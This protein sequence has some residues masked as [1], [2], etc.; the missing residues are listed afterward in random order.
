MNARLLRDLGSLLGATAL[1]GL[2]STAACTPVVRDFGTGGG[3]GGGAS[4]GTTSTS[5]STGGGGGS[6]A[7]TPGTKIACYGGPAGTKGVG[8]CLGGEKT[9]NAEGDGYG[10]CKGEVTPQP[11][12]CMTSADEDCDGKTDPCPLT[13]LWANAPATVGNDNV[14]HGVA[15]DDQGFVYVTGTLDGTIVFDA[16]AAGQVTSAG[17]DD[18]YVAKYGP[19][20]AFLWVKT[21]GDASSQTATAIAV[22]KNGHVYVGGYFDGKV[23]FGASYNFATK[24]GRDAFVLELDKNGSTL[25]AVAGGDMSDQEITSLV[26]GPGGEVIVGGTFGGSF[27][28]TG[29]PLLVAE[30]FQNLFLARFDASLTPLFAIAATGP[31]PHSLGGLAVAPD[32]SLAF[33]GSFEG[34]FGLYGPPTLNT[35]DKEDIVVGKINPA[36]KALVWAHGYN[37]AGQD[38]GAGVAVDSLGNVLFGGYFG[39]SLDLGSSIVLQS[40]TEAS[41]FVAK[42]SPTGDPLW[43]QRYGETFPGLSLPLVLATTTNDRVI[44]GGCYFN[45]A[46]FGGGPLSSAGAANDLGAVDAFLAEFESSGQYVVARSFGNLSVQAGLGLAIAPQGNL[47][48]C[49]ATGGQLDFGTGPVGPMD[50]NVISPFLAKLVP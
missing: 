34:G 21:Y 49:G 46:D 20:G 9:C 3:G 14:A 18:I 31:G 5:G 10:P 7:C 29:G 6:S 1:A 19:N 27:A 11:E 37:G 16:S 8:L 42:L 15:V 30:G 44:V 35:V 40:P 12:D 43:G 2:A 17:S 39:K 36:M 33:T 47:V 41:F 13:A 50:P 38:R 22:G 23:A 48:Y 32:G 25:S 24:G 45:T 28:F 4:T 26:V